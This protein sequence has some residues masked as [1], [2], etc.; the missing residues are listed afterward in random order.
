M[1]NYSEIKQFVDGHL[2]KKVHEG[3][4]QLIV[5]GDETH[6]MK[7]GLAARRAALEETLSTAVPFLRPFHIHEFKQEL[8]L[9]VRDYLLQENGE[10]KSRA[11]TIAAQ[12]DAAFPRRNVALR[13]PNASLS[14]A[15]ELGD[16]ARRNLEG[17]VMQSGYRRVADIVG[18]LK[19]PAGAM[20]R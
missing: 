4:V 15:D 8:E 17:H 7:L 6:A 16:T 19:P 13:H 20:A 12:I 9:F 3:I 2:P 10:G 11:Q 1:T 14:V 18:T 5:H